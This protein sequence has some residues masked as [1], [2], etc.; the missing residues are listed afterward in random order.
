MLQSTGPLRSQL[1]H[2]MKGQCLF[3]G[4]LLASTAVTEA[5]ESPQSWSRECQRGAFRCVTVSGTGTH[6]FSTALIHSETPTETGLVRRSTDTIDLEGDIVGRVL[7]HP[8]SEFDFVNN[9]LINTGQ[10]VF[11]GTVLNSGP[12]LIYDDSFRF[13]VNLATGETRGTVKLYRPLGSEFIQ[14]RLSIAGTG[15]TTA[16]DDPRV[17][18]EGICRI[19]APGSWRESKDWQDTGD[20]AVRQ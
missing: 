5:Q 8:V 20:R 6:Y 1:E 16:A 13:E 11:S 17:A 12:V 10:Q 4:L 15:T 18:Y 7:Y 3:A 9:T 19:R 2:D 14:C